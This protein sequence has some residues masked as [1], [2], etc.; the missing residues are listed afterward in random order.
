MKFIFTLLFVSFILNC[1]AQVGSF[2]KL[3]ESY[4]QQLQKTPE[5]LGFI[6]TDRDIY[7]AGDELLYSCY[8]LNTQDTFAISKVGY[9]FLLDENGEM[10]QK[11]VVKIQKQKGSNVLAL[12]KTLTS[13]VYYLAATTAWMQNFNYKQHLKKIIVREGQEGKATVTPKPA[14][15]FEVGFFPESGSLLANSD[16]VIAVRSLTNDGAAAKINAVVK[17]KAG[18][19]IQ[20]FSTNEN[21]STT[22]N[23]NIDKEEALSIECEWIGTGKKKI[24]ALRADN[25]FANISINN[26]KKLF[27]KVN[28]TK[29]Q[30]PNFLLLAVN[31]GNIIFKKEIT[32]ANI[33]ETFAFNKQQLPSGILK[34]MLVSED[35]KIIAERLTHISNNKNEQPNIAVVNMPKQAKRAAVQ[36]EISNN[37]SL[38]NGSISIANLNNVDTSLQAN[39]TYV[40]LLTTLGN[41]FDFDANSIKSLEDNAELIDEILL[42]NGFVKPVNAQLVAETPI[43]LA[44]EYGLYIAG[45]ITKPSTNTGLKDGKLDLFVIN[46]DS[47][48]YLFSENCNEKGEFIVRD[49]QLTRQNTIFFSSSKVKAIEK[50]TEVSFYKHFT[51][52]LKS[53]KFNKNIFKKPGAPKKVEVNNLQSKAKTLLEV[54]IKATRQNEYQKLNQEYVSPLFENADQSIIV[55]QSGGLTIWQLLQRDIN[56][57]NI[58]NTDSGRQ[59]FFNRFAG[60]DAFSENG[61]VNGVQFFLNEQPI[62]TFEMETIF[63]EDIAYIKVFKGGLGFV[64]GAPSGAIALYTKKGKSTKDWRDKGFEKYNMQGYEPQYIGYNMKYSKPVTELEVDYR[65]TLYWDANLNIPANS[66]K[67]IQFFTDDSNGPWQITILGINQNNKPVMVTK[68]IE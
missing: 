65:P 12:S 40:S 18:K 61:G 47:S 68:I 15:D 55:N 1:N 7:A 37:N 39:E 60:L 24:Y 48:K 10:L 43:K 57:I 2:E 50:L 4:Q 8:F 36:A 28:S 17:N 63:I 27:I 9:V 44:P 42:T 20:N 66:K 67:T 58:A 41:K 23:I 19:E 6:H 54:R 31:A 22:F 51:D 25:A 56:G 35:G 34:I 11:Q 49:L 38:L 46:A 13:G 5:E 62:S 45:K 14:S 52:T 33:E 16:Q 30:E 26:R 64:L 59:V 3:L 21:G 29:A 32:A 53:F